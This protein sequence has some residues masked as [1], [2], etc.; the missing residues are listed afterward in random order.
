VN[1]G[2]LSTAA[3]FNYTPGQRFRVI[4]CDN[5]AFYNHCELWGYEGFMTTDRVGYKAGGASIQSSPYSWKLLTQYATTADPWISLPISAYNSNIAT[6]VTVTVY[7][8]TTGALP[9][10]DEMWLDVDFLGTT[11]SPLATFVSG[12][13]LTLATPANLSTDTSDWTGVA[14]ARANSHAYVLGDEL[15][16]ASTGGNRLFVCTTAGTSAGSLPGGYATATDGSAITD[17]GAVFTAVRRFTITLSLTPY[18]LVSGPINAVIRVANNA[19]AKT[20]W[21]DPMLNLS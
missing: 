20:Y 3:S 18:P 10:N 5:G 7:G 8:C 19:T 9:T 15:S 4:D 21:F 1:S 14:G 17:G 13:C 16:I 6:T 11:Y 12:R 2:A